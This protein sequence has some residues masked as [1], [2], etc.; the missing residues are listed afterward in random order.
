MQHITQSIT[1]K[2]KLDFPIHCN[3]KIIN[4]EGKN[5]EG[6]VI[7]YYSFNLNK[8]LEPLIIIY[9]GTKI[10]LSLDKMANTYKEKFYKNK[11]M[12]IKI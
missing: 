12:I 6:I 5:K 4:G 2:L 1:E 11:S 10:D 9:P 8:E 3:V 7:G